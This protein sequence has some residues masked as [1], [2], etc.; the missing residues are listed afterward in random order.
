MSERIEKHGLKVSPALYSFIE[1]EALPGS[2][3]DPDKF[4]AGFAALAVKLM[5]ESRALLAERDGLQAAIDGWHKAHPAR[6][7]DLA[8][9]TAFLKEIGYL[10]PE[11]ADFQI[12]TQNVDPEI[13][14]T[15]GPQLVV[16][17]TNAR[18]ALNAAN[19]RWGSLYDALYGTDAIPQDGDLAAGKGYNPK[20]GERVIAFARE[21][22]DQAVPLDGASHKDAAGYTL[23]RGA[24]KI[25]LKDGSRVDLKDPSQFKGY[26]GP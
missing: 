15:A 4:W 8:A 3:V 17:L 6:P 12:G 22:L 23:V 16:P 21:F 2:G 7:I 13:A 5:P 9:Y 26:Q 25:A 10:V 14:V 24:L 1:K 19:A 11:G 20:R 18:F